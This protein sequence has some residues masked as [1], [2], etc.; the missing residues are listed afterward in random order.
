MNSEKIYF[1]ELE[2]A[3]DAYSDLYERNKQL[4]IEIHRLNEAL[5][6]KSK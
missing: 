5:K 6:G 1:K 3:W 2:L 4:V